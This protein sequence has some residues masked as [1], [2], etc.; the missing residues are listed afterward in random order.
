MLKL[1]LEKWALDIDDLRK[2]SLESDK[3]RTRERFLALYLIA[4]GS[5]ATRVASQV[6]RDPQT[7]MK[8]VHLFN[9][10]GPEALYYK[11][12]GGRRPLVQKL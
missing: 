4:Q 2:L 12:T 10:K 5:C 6:G 8:W 11:K 7:L 3:P 1:E 9:S